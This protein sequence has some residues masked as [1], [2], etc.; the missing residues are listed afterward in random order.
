MFIKTATMNRIEIF[1]QYVLPVITGAISWVAAQYVTKNKRKTDA[2]NDLN[3]SLE[4]MVD[5][6]TQTLNTLT[7]VQKKN[8]ELINGQNKMQNELIQLRKENEELRREVQLLNEKLENVKTI[9]VTK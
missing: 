6:Y 2:I 9:R 1:V 3:Q 7:E 4:T 8:V 5:K